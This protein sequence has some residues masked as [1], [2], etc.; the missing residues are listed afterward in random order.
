MGN[1]IKIIIRSLI[2]SKS[3]TFLNLLGL[4][5]GLVVFILITLYTTYEF[6]YDAN[7]ENKEK[8]YRV[9]QEQKG[10]FYLGSNYFAVTSA[11][12]APA[13]MADYP[14]V[15]YATRFNDY[16]NVLIKANDEVILEPVVYSTDPETFKIFTFEAIQGDMS[17][18]LEEKN[19]AVLTES[20]ALKYFGKTD[21]LDEVIHFRNE[22]PMKVVGVIKDMPEN[23]HFV[24]DIIIQYESTMELDDRNMTR[25][26]N[27]SYHTYLMLA[28]GATIEGLQSKMPEM[29][30]KYADDPI[31][32]DGQSTLFTLQPLPEVH[33]TQGVNFDIAPS[34]DPQKLYIY[35]GIAFMVLIIAGINYVNL[36][37]ARSIN[38][39][40]EIGI[41]KVVGAQSGSL[42]FQ[43]LLES[44]LMVFLSLVLSILILLLVLP[45]FS[46]FIDRPLSLDFSDLSLWLFLLGLTF[47][48][49][50]L[51]GLYPSWVLTS[52]K[53]VAALKG[54]GEIRQ[55]GGLFRNMLVVFQ[56]AISS[57]LIISATVLSEQLNF[58]QSADMGYTRDQIIVL[59]LRDRSIRDQINV[60]NDELRRIP[61]VISVA[62]ASSLPNNISSSTNARWPGKDKEINLPIYTGRVDYDYFDLFELKFTEGEGFRRGIESDKKA[63][64]LNETAVKA[65]GWDEP[66]GKQY[67]TN[68]GDT[69]RVIGVLKDFNQHSLHLAIEPLQLFFREDHSRI[70]VK[71]AGD[72]LN[73][74]VKAIEAKF[75]T[76]N[77]EYPFDYNYFDD[78]FD[79][80]YLS[81][82]K[83]AKLAQ[84]FTGLTIL[85][86][87]LGLY[88][89]ASHKVQQRIKEVGV[90]KVLGASIFRI[91]TLLSRDFVKLL[92]IA[93]LIA[94][95]AAYYIMNG[96]LDGFAFHIDIGFLTVLI[97]LG[98]MILV[99]G[100][101]VGYRTYRAAVRNPIEALREE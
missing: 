35:L 25:W 17:T 55:R 88:G 67:I 79:R 26:N 30:A 84:W 82:M 72:R 78:I 92:L 44:F 90:R 69:G 7:H 53:P 27:N 19:T 56:F 98:M 93:F 85:V 10:N 91:L 39:T 21:V 70:S 32:E 9:Y 3:Y 28:D 34:S 24:M 76:F 41:R 5:S 73:E 64:I 52:F 59:S 31:D 37:T 74:T 87:C 49:S 54:K 4:T 57:G 77:P 42:V 1:Q 48:L 83:T 50:I 12:M 99:A 46:Q 2:R 22:H 6:G 33:F 75:N 51:A 61:G 47:G 8:I 100:L 89:L 71:I 95:P 68:N 66:I 14:E 43:F 101:T 62:G 11:P 81:E 29:R 38:R 15:A 40:K 63:V 16:Y 23:S 65:I 97:T 20:I 18:F 96:W 94:A 13:L 80:A 36:A 60:F 45:I 58:I 86:A